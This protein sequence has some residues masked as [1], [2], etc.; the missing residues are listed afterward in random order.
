MCVLL[1]KFCL[2]VYVEGPGIKVGIYVSRSCLRMCL[3]VY[4]LMCDSIHTHNTHREN[5]YTHATHT[6]GL[7]ERER[8]EI[9]KH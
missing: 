4:A 6:Q 5:T 3:I 2:H 8:T 9:C 1:T 7:R